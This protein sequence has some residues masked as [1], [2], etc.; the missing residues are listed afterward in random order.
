MVDVRPKTDNRN[1]NGQ[2]IDL[3]PVVTSDKIKYTQ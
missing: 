2:E 1:N 3:L